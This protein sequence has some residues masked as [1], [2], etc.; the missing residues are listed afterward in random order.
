[1][2]VVSDW[3]RFGYLGMCGCAAYHLFFSLDGLRPLQ[4]SH[5]LSLLTRFEITDFQECPFS[6]CHQTFL[7]E[8]YV[9]S[10]GFKPMFLVGCHSAI[11]FGYDVRY[12]FIRLI[13]L[14]ISQSISALQTMHH[15]VL[16]T[17]CTLSLPQGHHRHLST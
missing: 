3:C 12:F 13:R 14:L 17:Y 9:S 2:C 7:P 11:N 6:H 5:L 4:N 1:M 8:P 10:S 16:A 15:Y